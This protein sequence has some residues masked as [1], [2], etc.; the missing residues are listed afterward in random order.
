MTITIAIATLC[1][2]FSIFAVLIGW[3]CCVVAAQADA[4]IEKILDE[5]KRDKYE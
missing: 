2:T 5:M 4:H 1:C 3:S